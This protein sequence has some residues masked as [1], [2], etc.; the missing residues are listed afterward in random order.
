MPACQALHTSETAC[1]PANLDIEDLNAY[2]LKY[3]R[4]KNLTAQGDQSA[5]HHQPVDLN[6]SVIPVL[7]ASLKGFTKAFCIKFPSVTEAPWDR[8]TRSSWQAHQVCN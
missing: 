3:V 2:L 7:T 8:Q 5:A 6:I 4:V 1:T